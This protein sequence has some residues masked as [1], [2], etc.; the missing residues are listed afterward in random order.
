MEKLPR[1][2]PDYNKPEYKED[3]HKIK[4]LLK[5]AFPRAEELKRKLMSQYEAEKQ[6]LEGK[7]AE[8]VIFLAISLSL[9]PPPIDTLP[10]LSPH[11]SLLPPP[12]PPLSLSPFHILS[13][14]NHHHQERARRKVEEEKGVAEQRQAREE[15]ERRSQ[16]EAERVAAFLA[17]MTQDTPTEQQQ[18]QQE[19]EEEEEGNS[20]RSEPTGGGTGD[21]GGD[22]GIETCWTQTVESVAPGDDQQQQQLASTMGALT[23]E[24]PYEAGGPPGERSVTATNAQLAQVLP[25]SYEGPPID[26]QVTVQQ[27]SSQPGTHLAAPGHTGDV[28]I[29]NARTY[30]SIFSGPIPPADQTPPPNYSDIPPPTNPYYSSAGGQGAQIPPAVDPRM[31]QYYQYYGGH[32]QGVPHPAVPYVAQFSTASSSSWGSVELPTPS[33]H[34]NPQATPTEGESFVCSRFTPSL[35][36]PL[37]SLSLFL[38]LSLSSSLSSSY[39]GK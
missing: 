20:A 15:A 1:Q 26:Q 14:D 17:G 3:R 32:Y 37:S 2:Y 10:S 25:P 16:E 8:E 28:P 19:E 33:Y 36:L 11:L 6:A 30:R 38:S 24:E 34:M 31:Q 21:G 22:T 27:S 23:I 13:V 5:E 7:L 18:Q 9:P 35:S 29:S 39:P 4:R 12:P